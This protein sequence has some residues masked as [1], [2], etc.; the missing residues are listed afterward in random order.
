MIFVLLKRIENTSVAFI[1]FLVLFVLA[2]THFINRNSSNGA[3]ITFYILTTS[4]CSLNPTNRGVFNWI[5]YHE[6]YFR[7]LV[8]KEILDKNVDINS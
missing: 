5:E 2:F 6:K 3:M 8:A 1:A 7:C 4:R